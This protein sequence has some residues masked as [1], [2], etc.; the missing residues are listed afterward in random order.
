MKCA[1]CNGLMNEVDI[2]RDALKR[3]DSMVMSKYVTKI[4]CLS[5]REEVAVRAL[6]KIVSLSE[7]EDL[8]DG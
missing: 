4:G 8:N 2:A 5:D 1:T 6:L 3:L 7:Q